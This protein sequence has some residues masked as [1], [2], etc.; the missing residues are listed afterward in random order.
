MRLAR[1]GVAGA[2]VA[3]LVM[4]TFPAFA[5]SGATLVAI[6]TAEPNSS[7]TRRVRAELQGLGVDVIVLKP[8]DEGSPSRAPLEQAARSVGAVAAV[9]LVASSEGKVEVWV[10]DRVTGK[11]V[12]RELEAS[13]SGASDAAVAIGSVELLRASLMELH[14]G[15]PLHGDAPAT[16]KV[17][18]LALPAGSSSRMPRLG[19]SAGAGAELGVRG[20]GPSADADIAVWVRLASHFG[21]RLLGHTSLS[22]AHVSVSS[23]GVDVR[24]QL[25]GAMVT[26][27]L[28]DESSVWVPS[29][30]AGMAAAH[31]SAIGTAAPPFVSASDGTWSPAPLAGLGLAWSFAPGLRLRGD[32]LAALTVPPLHVTA[33]GTDI[34]SWGA[35]AL[36]VSLGLEVMWAP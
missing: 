16:E 20:L 21:L 18:S 1:L 10:A 33:P 15:E 8:P 31:V 5:E 6:V 32:G 3:S 11:A 27:A 34:G 19:L 2:I 28:V 25:F 22:P 14:S 12:V 35:P 36:I 23:G 17:Q 24:S 9:R 26:Y 13:E 7:L 4:A 29:V 30:S